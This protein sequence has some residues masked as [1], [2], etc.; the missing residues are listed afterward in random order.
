MWTSLNHPGGFGRRWRYT[1]DQVIGLSCWNFQPSQL[2]AVTES[3]SGIATFKRNG[4]PIGSISWQL[5]AVGQGWKIDLSYHCNQQEREADIS[6]TADRVASSGS[7]RWW[8]QCPGCMKRCGKLFIVPSSGLP[9][10][11]TCGSITYASR[12]AM[13][14]A[15]L[16]RVLGCAY[17]KFSERYSHP[18]Q[19]PA[20]QPKA[21]KVR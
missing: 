7:R 8:W 14:P 2:L 4:V 1:T 12:H 10:C 19:S 18:P 9:R 3:R 16:D 21:I 5:R 15:R 11:R 6:L 17:A 13:H 20:T